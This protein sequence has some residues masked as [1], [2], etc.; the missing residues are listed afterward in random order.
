VLVAGQAGLAGSVTVGDNVQIGGNA[1]IADHVTIG[2]SARIAAKSGVI[3]D[4]RRDATVAGYPAM[5]RN[6]WL[7]SIAIKAKRK[8][9]T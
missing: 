1:G 9:R 2:A 8:K 6:R 4:I 5:D 3:G 7:R